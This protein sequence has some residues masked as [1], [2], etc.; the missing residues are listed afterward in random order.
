MSDI[1]VAISEVILNILLLVV[2]GLAAAAVAAIKKRLDAQGIEI[3][4]IIAQAAVGAV[5]QIGARQGWS[6]DQKLNHALHR[7]RQAAETYGL[8]LSDEQ[9]KTFIEQAVAE[10]K[11]AG[12]EL[13][14][15]DSPYDGSTELKHPL[16]GPAVFANTSPG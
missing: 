2:T 15:S 13:V 8:K 6:P 9:W 7:A 4:L 3:G 12:G 5:E 14:Q 1:N 10:M 16:V 11:R